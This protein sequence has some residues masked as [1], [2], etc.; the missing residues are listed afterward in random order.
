[1]CYSMAAMYGIT[2]KLKAQ[3]VEAAAVAQEEARNGCIVCS[4]CNAAKK[5]TKFKLPGTRI[6]SAY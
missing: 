2:S 6:T 1:M 5:V 4:P 3:E